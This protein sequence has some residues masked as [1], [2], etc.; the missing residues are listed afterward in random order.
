MPGWVHYSL[1]FVAYLLALLAKP[2]AVTTP[3][4]AG[5]LA[6]WAL[7][8]PFRE[9]ALRLAPWVALAVP[10][11]LVTR[12]AQPVSAGLITPLWTRPLIA[13]DALAFYLLKLLLPLELGVDYGRT[14]HYML[15]HAWGYLTW[16]VPAVVVV[17]AWL[18]RGKRP[19]LWAA[20]LVFVAAILP[21]SGIVP[22][23]YQSYSTTADRY[24]Y[25]ALLGPA[26]ALAWVLNRSR[27]FRALAAAG[28]YLA[29]LGVLCSL[30]T[31]WWE[32]DLSLWRRA[33]Q[34]NP[35]STVA[36]GN[37]GKMLL[38]QGRVEEAIPELEADLRLIPADAERH[39]NLAI[40][41]ERLV[42]IREAVR[43]YR[44]AIRLDP[45]YIPPYNNLGVVYLRTRR[46]LQAAELFREVLR[47][48][49]THPVALRNLELTERLI[50]QKQ[51]R[52]RP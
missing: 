27:G 15:A 10:L 3:L 4:I 45:D 46:L 38:A 33:A 16:I 18:G 32:T 31:L 42:R 51:Q 20:A 44:E 43:E 8:R 41:L 23:G 30:Q 17:A 52:G 5:V 24:L 22:F 13:G 9:T 21:V 34:V 28:I 39:Y 36:H 1:A 11:A 12:S 26:L 37:L 50:A 47:R 48:D 2:A 14:P 49:P 19:L 7:R 29:L 35:T 25:V 40:A 6:G